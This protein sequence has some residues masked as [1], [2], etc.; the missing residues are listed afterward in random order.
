MW[1]KVFENLI[2]C[3]DELDLQHLSIVGSAT[4]K[5]IYDIEDVDVYVLVNELSQARFLKIINLVKQGFSTNLCQKELLWQVETRRGPL[6]STNNNERQIHVLLDDLTT[7]KK[8]SLSTLANW[9]ING[10]KIFGNSISEII[11]YNLNNSNNKEIISSTLLDITEML[12][13]LHK[14]IINYKVWTFFDNPSLKEEEK[15]ISSSE[16][17]WHFAKHCL[18]T[19]KTML[20]LIKYKFTSSGNYLKIYEENC[21]AMEERDRTSYEAKETVI[22]ELSFCKKQIQAA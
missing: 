2:S 8:T 18:V 15:T 5:N 16:E 17:Y 9:Q 6:K 7:I 21:L 19:S 1:K 20:D 13:S 11:N 4:I 22:K 14:E 3:H 12:D 10:N